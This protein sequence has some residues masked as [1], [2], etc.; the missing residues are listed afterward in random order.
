MVAAFLERDGRCLIQQRPPGGTRS[1]LWEFPGGKREPGEDDAQA[2]AR[3]CR[4]ELGLEVAVGPRL[5]ETEHEYPDL[6]VSLALYRCRLAAGSPRPRDGQTLAWAEPGRLA[7]YPFCEADRPFLERLRRGL[8]TT[9]R[10]GAYGILVEDGKVL[11]THTRTRGGLLLNFP[12]GA[13][14]L[15]EGPLAALRRELREETGLEVAVQGLVHATEGYHPSRDYPE[16]QLI[17]LYWRVARS[18]GELRLSGNGDDVERCVWLPVGELA[19][20]GLGDSDAE[21][22]GRL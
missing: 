14:E 12:G 4:E 15:G 2:L 9:F 11:L 7:E 8:P 17:K 21:L 20:A 13:V 1:G 5:W 3:E 10:V 22:L 6:C 19:R 16:N 18:G